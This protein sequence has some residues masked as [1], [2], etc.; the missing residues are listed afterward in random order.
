MFISDNINLD[1]IENFQ[2]DIFIN[3]ACP[4]LEFDSDKILNYES[5]E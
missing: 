4:G 2:A 3:F 5:L 1:E